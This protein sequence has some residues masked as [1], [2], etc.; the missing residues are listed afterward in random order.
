MNKRPEH[1]DFLIVGQ[2][3][4]GT[5]LAHFLARAGIRVLVL[6]K[7]HP[8]ASSLKAA[9]IINPITGRRYAK[10]WMIEQLLP[11]AK[12]TYLQLEQEFQIELWHERNLLRALPSI[13]D[14]NEWLRRSA[15]PDFK[16]W[17]A[18]Q[19]DLSGLEGVLKPVYAWGE[20]MGAAQVNF[21]A[22]LTAFRSKLKKDKALREEDF[23]FKK[24]D[25]G[26]ANPI[27]DGMEV[28][29]VVFCEGARAVANPFF[30]YLPFVPTKGEFLV[31]KIPGVD[32][33][34]MIK[35]GVTIVPAG[36]GTYWVGATSRFEFEDECPS[37][38]Q[39]AWLLNKL[40]N[41]LAVP[42][43]VIRHDAAIRPTVF[44]IRPF[45]GPHPKYKGLFIFNG[46]GT[47]GASLAPF[48]AHH[49]TRFLVDGHPLMPEVDIQRF[50][51]KYFNSASSHG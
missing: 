26:G 6:D 45:I 2:G 36:E 4:A 41:A 35:N 14:E 21:P 8:A 12:N 51:D 46:L 9:G 16:P 25:L 29:A 49:F 43:E 3:I 42:F 38:Q 13:Q 50:E 31:V 10:S 47:K 19:A 7:P 40:Q 37:A 44:D 27:Y 39:R 30:G 11:F 17:F 23:D 34:K 24:L 28:K 1:P 15:F 5:L 20:T 48:F 18:H 32:F 22:L 33:P